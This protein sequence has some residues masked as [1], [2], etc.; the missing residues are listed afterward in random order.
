MP[1]YLKRSPIRLCPDAD[2][3]HTLE[4]GAERLSNFW[5]SDEILQVF[6]VVPGVNRKELRLILWIQMWSV[7][8]RSERT[9][10]R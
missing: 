5:V 10:H 2:I 6:Q 7:S 1:T 9:G 8:D 4:E 3:R